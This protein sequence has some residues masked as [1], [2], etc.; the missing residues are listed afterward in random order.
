MVVF[1]LISLK[2]GILM[3]YE[4]TKEIDYA[5]LIEE[6]DLVNLFNL[7]SEKYK[8]LEITVNCKDKT[9]LKTNNI[10][11]IIT[12]SN[13][14]FKKIVS[15]SIYAR[16]STNNRLSLDIDAERYSNRVATFSIESVNEEEFNYIKNKLENWFIGV[17]QWYSYF[18][19]IDIWNLSF[20]LTVFTGIAILGYSNAEL[21]KS[22]V[23]ITKIV[24]TIFIISFLLGVILLLFAKPI[25]KLQNYIFPRIFFALGKQKNILSSI[26]NIRLGIIISLLIAI[27]LELTT[28]IFKNFINFLLH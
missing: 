14:N 13:D 24:G 4:I 12:Y 20:P 15:L 22:N 25:N 10:R 1:I 11:E 18:S 8:E 16:S 9:K 23:Y 7:V 26:T 19:K 2:E 17:R 28:N 6:E 5:I 21:H 3:F 27:V